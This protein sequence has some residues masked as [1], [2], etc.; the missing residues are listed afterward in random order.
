MI[1]LKYE[2]I[3]TP[4]ELLT[5]MIEHFHYGFVDED[6]VVYDTSNMIAFQKACKRKWA[7][8]SSHRLRRV[9]YGICFDFVEFER[10]WFQSHGYLVQTFFIWFHL[11]YENSYSSHTY[12][13][14]QENE[15]YY[16]FEYSIF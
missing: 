1:H 14:Y 16:Y 11:P 9:Q 6:G 12:L 8:S 13:I 7:L 15:K 3:S 4:K 2:E 10:K 5:Y